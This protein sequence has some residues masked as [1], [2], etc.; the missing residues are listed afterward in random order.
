MA[1]ALAILDMQVLLALRNSWVV[2][3]LVQHIANA[4]T[5]NVFVLMDGLELTVSYLHLFTF[6]HQS[7]LISS[8]AEMDNVLTEHVVAI[9][10]GSKQ[11]AVP[12]VPR[13]A[14]IQLNQLMEHALTLF[15]TA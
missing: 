3:L 6:V 1:F 7:A 13:T 2:Q 4:M 5:Q 14:Q 8:A 10:V 15:A 11:I 9:V 12:H